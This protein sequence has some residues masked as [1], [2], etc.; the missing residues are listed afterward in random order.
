MAMPIMELLKDKKP[1][2]NR[3]G[4]TDRQ[5]RVFVSYTAEAEEAQ[6]RGYT[7]NQICRAVRDELMQKGE[8][9]ECWNVWDVRNVINAAK[10]ASAQ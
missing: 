5:Y 4:R 9:D 6:K 8:W 7:W 1:W 10:R 3:P 2:R